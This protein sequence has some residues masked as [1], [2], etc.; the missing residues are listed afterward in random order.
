MWL[1]SYCEIT[2]VR[3][4][5]PQGH[6]M[7]IGYLL[8]RHCLEKT[9]LPRGRRDRTSACLG[10]MSRRHYLGLIANFDFV[11]YFD[12]FMSS[13]LPHNPHPIP[14]HNPM[15]YP[16]PNPMPKLIFPSS[17]TLVP[18]LTLSLP[19]HTSLAFTKMHVKTPSMIS[20]PI[21]TPTPIINRE[22]HC[23]NQREL[24][25]FN[26]TVIQIHKWIQNLGFTEHA[27]GLKNLKMRYYIFCT[28]SYVGCTPDI[29]CK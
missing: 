28:K 8:S 14:Q 6:M 7:H 9:C 18:A 26:I 1:W 12:T 13:R 2:L 24:G 27:W 10:D 17:S 23:S 4:S 16:M 22:G 19:P 11:A 15:P 21:T 29:L 25:F 3:W 20:H 5:S